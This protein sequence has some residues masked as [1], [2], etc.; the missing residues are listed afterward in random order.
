[1]N[2]R[3][4]HCNELTRRNIGETV[5][6]SG[7]VH[8][9]RD[10]GGVIF[11]DLRDREGLTQVVFNPETAP[12]AAQAAHDLRDEFVVRVQGTVVARLAGTENNAL[13]TGEIE[14]AAERF[15]LL[16]RAETPPF[17]LQGRVENEDLRLAHRYLDLRRAPMLANLK[18]RHKLTKATRDFLDARGF[19]EIE[20]PI[21]AKSTPEGAR[22]FL[23]PSRVHRGEFYALSQ[24]PQQ[25]KQLLMVGGIERYFQIAK[26]FRD[27]DPRA[28]RITELTQIDM[29]MSFIDAAGIQELIEGLL[30]AIFKATRGVDIP[31]PFRRMP[32]REAMDR[33][34]SDKPDLRFG[35]ELADVSDVFRASAFKVFR[36][37]LDAGGRVKA[38]NAKGFASITTGQIEQ[39]TDIAKQAGAKGLAFIKVENGEWKSPIVKFF[40]DAEKAALAKT[41]RIEEGDLILFGADTWDVACTTLGR[42]RLAIADIQQL[43]S[44][45]DRLEFLWV[46]D[47]PLLAYS[48]EENKWNAVHHPFTRP[49]ADDLPLLEKGDFGAVRAEAYD[50]VLNGVEIGGGS[51]RIHEGDLQARL[52][53]VLGISPERQMLLFPHL[54]KAFTFGAPPHGGIALGVD[55]LLMLIC[56]ADNIRDVIAF[57]KNNRGQDLMVGSPSEAEPRQLRELG[58]TLKKWGG[59]PPPRRFPPRFVRPS[60]FSFRNG[61]RATEADCR[62]T[63]PGLAKEDVLRAPV[64]RARARVEQPVG[65][66]RHMPAPAL[67]NVVARVAVRALALRHLPHIPAEVPD[68]LRRASGGMG[69]DW[70]GSGAV[71]VGPRRLQ[72]PGAPRILAARAALR[73]MLPFL[74]GRQPFSGPGRVGARVG[75]RDMHHRVAAPARRRRAI[76][77]VRQKIPGVRRTVSGFGQKPGKVR[78]GDRKRVNRNGTDFRPSRER[79]DPLEGVIDMLFVPRPRNV[80]ALAH[81]VTGDDRPGK[82]RQTDHAG[83]QRRHRAR[84]RAGQQDVGQ[85]SLAARERR[86]IGAGKA[87]ALRGKKRVPLLRGPCR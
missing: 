10:H 4:H 29:E 81:P 55:R 59:P 13:T 8:S 33:F 22:E 2:Y 17:P 3:T 34:G 43:A 83:R 25:Y 52:F 54:L 21:L 80:S 37:A 68:T 1:M 46:T 69:I 39:L 12:A 73:R 9:R 57:P 20:T 19:L 15:D 85:R 60:P 38:L 78:V 11:V 5:T 32:Y 18:A 48:P 63:V 49:K 6:L 87:Q 31:V 77:P 47:F 36:A 30:A 62:A 82:I 28:D 74:L 56:G 26:C 50:V 24:S 61:H 67:Q 53:D 40:T 45:P 72:R 75:T 84:H 65:I 66:V 41:L 16:N 23:V 7:W 58:L 42:I 44:D 64:R 27:E 71:L 35:L 70:R 76:N 14:V 51:I 79:A 86:P